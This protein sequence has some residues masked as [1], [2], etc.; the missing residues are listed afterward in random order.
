MDEKKGEVKLN[1]GFLMSKTAVFHPENSGFRSE[2]SGFRLKKRRFSLRKRPFLHSS[3]TSIT[4]L[5]LHLS[6]HNQLA[7]N[8][9]TPKVIDV[10]DKMTKKHRG[11]GNVIE[12]Y[13]PSKGKSVIA[14][15]DNASVLCLTTEFAEVIFRTLLNRNFALSSDKTGCTRICKT[16]KSLFCFDIS[17]VCT[18]FAD[19]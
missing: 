7:L 11:G 17:H 2:N 14:A 8:R 19:K 4:H 16:K 13:H 3:I 18:I 6:L 9:L 1:Y 12:L 15:V 10:I 5:S